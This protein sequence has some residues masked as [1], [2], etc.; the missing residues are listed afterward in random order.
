MD[1]IDRIKSELDSSKYIDINGEHS[2][3]AMI[4]K[5]MEDNEDGWH[6]PDIAWNYIEATIEAHIENSPV[7]EVNSLMQLADDDWDEATGDF[8]DHEVLSQF[9]Q[10]AII[11]NASSDYL[12]AEQDSLEDFLEGK[13]LFYN[14]IWMPD[15]DHI[16]LFACYVPEELQIRDVDTL[17][18]HLEQRYRSMIIDCYK[19]RGHGLYLRYDEIIDEVC[20][21]ANEIDLV[22]C[23]FYSDKFNFQLGN[24]K[25]RIKENILPDYIIGTDEI[26][27]ETD[28][29]LIL[30]ILDQNYSL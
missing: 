19:K 4:G 29:F 12:K 3:W 1:I 8:I 15:M 23:L 9:I 22:H 13:K 25:A 10:K 16:Q 28:F 2:D 20:G 21:T 27:L 7:E 5:W 24:L 30:D 11:N 18:S 17:I 14:P 26:E 6:F